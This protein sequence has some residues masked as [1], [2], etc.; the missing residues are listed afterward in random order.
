MDRLLI[1]AAEAAAALRINKYTLYKLARESRI[2]CVRIGRS[3][4]FQPEELKDWVR[5]LKEI[6]Q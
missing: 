4:R 3:V 2:P 5:R 6:E 1:D